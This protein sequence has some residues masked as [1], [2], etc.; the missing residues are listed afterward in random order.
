[1]RTLDLKLKV[2]SF[3]H[4]YTYT[5]THL[6][7]CKNTKEAVLI[8]P[9]LDYNP[10]NANT[11]TVFIDRVLGYISQR[12]IKLSHIIETHAHADHLTSAQY[13]KSKIDA[14]TVIGHNISSVQSFF[15]KV[16]NFDS[17]FKVDGSQ[18]DKL[19]KHKEGLKFGDCEILAMHTPG[20]TDDSMSYIIGDCAFIGDTLFSPD[21]GSARC[22][23][24]G[25][26][27]EKLYDSVQNIYN[28]GNHMK[29]Y[30]CHDYPPKSRQPKAMFMSS[31]QQ[32]KN[33]HLN[34][35]TT[36]TA[37]IKMRNKRDAKLN[38]PRLIIPAIQVNITSGELP[39]PENNGKTY[40]KIP[41]NV[42]GNGLN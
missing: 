35:T 24:P 3:Y 21:Y 28:L 12:N 26:S 17:S 41:L 33:V 2:K 23:F 20:H 11:S 19:L 27:S 10:N 18:F 37:F 40:L 13:I 31:E 4:E 8:D 22:D 25:G 1:M 38:Q 5:W 29:L 34:N 14:Q 30:L 42:I 9:V 39:Q 7:V 36:K 15:K 32:E 16:F 6:V